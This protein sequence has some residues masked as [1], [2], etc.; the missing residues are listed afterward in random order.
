MKEIFCNYFK[1]QNPSFLEKDLIKGKQAKYEQLVS[2]IND[3]YIDLRNASIKK[4]FVKI[5]FQRKQ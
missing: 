2:N 3:R 4:Q 5:K 1:I